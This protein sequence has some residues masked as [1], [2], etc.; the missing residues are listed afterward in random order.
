MVAGVNIVL[1]ADRRLNGG[2]Y[3]TALTN[4]TISQ[5]LGTGTVSYTSGSGS[6]TR[7]GTFFIGTDGQVHFA[8]D[9]AFPGTLYSVTVQSAPDVGVVFGTTA[10][11]TAMTGTDASDYIYGGN[12]TAGNGTG[13]DTISAGLGN[14]TVF[15]GDGND[16][17]YGG[18]G[19]DILYGMSG[20]DTL[21]G[22]AGDDRLNGGGGNDTLFGGDG[23]DS[24]DGGIGNDSIDGGIG[25][26]RVDGGAGNDTIAL[27]EGSNTGYGGTGGDTI[28]AGSGTDV[29]YGGAGRDSISAGDGSDTIFGGDSADTIDGGAGA[30]TIWGE[31]GN[32]SILGGDGNDVIHGDDTAPVAITTESMT[33]NAQGP[34]G[35]D[36][37]NGFVQDTGNINVSVS[38]RDDGSTTSVL[39]SNSAIFTNGNAAF[40]PTSSIQI[41]GT[42]GATTTTVIDFAAD[43]AS[44]VSDQVSNV[45]FFITDI[46]MVT[47]D[48]TNNFQDQVIILAYA[49]DGTLVPVTITAFGGDTVSSSGAGAGNNVITAIAGNDQ[50]DTAAGAAYISIPGPVASIVVQFVNA[51]GGTTNHGIYLSDVRFTT[52]APT[53]GDDTLDGGAGDDQIFGEAGNDVIYGRDGVDLIY[54]G[55]GNDVIDDEPG[56]PDG[57]SAD[58]FYGDAGDDIMWMGGGNDLGYGGTGNDAVYGQAGD[59]RLFGDAGNDTLSGDDG[60]D[61]LFGGAGRDTLYGGTG[62]DTL[63]GG[64]DA[65]VLNGGDGNDTLQG[66]AGNDT[67]SGDAGNDL[68]V[69][70]AGN[71]TIFGGAGDDTISLAN[72]WGADIVT[73]GETTETTGDTLSG[74][75]L[76]GNTT[77]TYTGAESGT[78]TNGGD[79]AS[80][81]EIERVITGSGADTINASAA[82][83][84]IMVE[85]G[86]GSDTIIGGSGND[87]IDAGSGNDTINAGA[88]ND[89]IMAGTGA[90]R[91][92]AGSGNDT[93]D[94]GGQDGAADV[95]VL[96]NGFGRDTLT[97]FDAI[98]VNGTNSFTSL[99]TL[100]VTGLLDA[101]GNPVNTRDVVVTDD[102]AG[103]ALLTFPGGEQLVLQGLSPSAASNE[104]LLNAI[105]IPLPDG[106]VSGTAGDDLIGAGYTDADG[107]RI[108]GNDS[109]LAG[110]T[111]N[112]DLIE[113]GAGNDTIL[114]G[115]G[116]DL[117]FAGTGNDTL[118]GGAGDDTLFGQA[119]RDTLY[120]GDGNDIVDGG[121]GGTEGDTLYGGAGNDQIIGDDGADLIAGDAGNDTIYANGGDDTITVADGFGVDTVSGGEANETLGDTLDASALTQGS[122][123]DLSAGI[124][125][126]PEDGTLTSG[127]NTVTFTE[128]ERIVLGAADDSVVG[129]TG[130]D[131]VVTGAGADIVNAGQGDDVIDLGAGAP[132]GDA[133]LVILQ[134]DFGRDVIFNLD[135]PV[136]NPDGSYTAIDTLDVSGLTD[137]TG[138]PVNTRDVVVSDDGAGNAVLTFPGGESLTLMGIDPVAASDEFFLNALGIPMSDGTVS[139]TAGDDLID[140]GYVDADGDAVDGD[141]AILPGSA[142]NDDLI[143]AGAGNDTVYAGD[144][145]DQVAGGAGTD[146]IYGGDGDDFI[147]GGSNMDFDPFVDADELYGGAGDD[148]IET[149]YQSTSGS[150]VYGGDG[151]DFLIDLGGT[152]SDDTFYGGAGMD[153]IAGG[154]GN[155]TIYGGT[156]DDYSEGGDGDDTFVINDGENYDIVIGGETGETIGDTLDASG[157]T[158][159]TV[160]DL[161]GP[162]Q[163]TLTDTA[164][165]LDGDPATDNIVEFSEIER[166]FLG[167]G[168]DTVF[169]GEGDDVVD[170]GAGDD[171]FRLFPGF[172]NDTVTGGEAGE[173]AGDTLDGA[174]LTDGVTVT[175]TGDGAGTL[176]D[177]AN[178]VTFAEMETIVTGSGADTI[179]GSATDDTILS[180]AGADTV[181]GG[182]GNDTIDLGFADGATDTLVL[183]DG[184]GNDIVTAFEG[185]IDN[186]DGTY[187]GRDQLDVSQL[188][189][190]DGMPVNVRDVVVTDDGAGNAVLTFPG[191]ETLTLP[192]IDPVAATDPM[193][194]NAMGIPL[195]D[196]TVYGTAGDDLIDA[197]YTGDADGDM[198]DGNDAILPGDSGNDDVIVAGD[199]NDTVLAGAGNDEVFGGSGND[200]LNGGAGDDTLFGETG[201]DTFVLDDG[202]G[203]DRITGGE[204]AGGAETDTIDGSGLTQGVSVTFSGAEAGTIFDGTDTL[205]FTEIEAIR[206]GAGADTI[207]GGA[208]DESIDAGAGDD[209]ID[210]GAGS[211]LIRG[212]AGN[213]TITFGRGDTISG[214]DG[215]GSPDGDDLFV[216]T[217]DPEAGPADI[218]IAGGANGAG[219][220]TLQLGFGADL[221]TLVITRDVNGSKSGTVQLDD[222]SLLSFSDI[223][224]IICFTPGTLIATPMGARD[225]ATLRIGDLVVTRDHGLQPIRWIQQR[226]VEAH[227][228]FAPIRIRPGV[229][230]GLERDLIVSPQHRMLFQGYRAELLF[231]ESEVLVAAKHLVDGL[232]V[233][234]DIGGTV[235]Y[236]HMM[237]DQHEVVYAEGAATESFH[238][239]ALGLDAIHDAARAELFAIFPGLRSDVNLYG[240]TARRCLKRHE[241]EL[242]RV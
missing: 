53:A 94:L 239:G 115:E 230:T 86:A 90:D 46:D 194:L 33:W 214:D 158:V 50:P 114:A 192:G 168:N 216:L 85:T 42:A 27:G 95:L 184:S 182:A 206:T 183:Q 150:T 142:G 76:T 67:L 17:V 79:T 119:G 189:D 222:G 175:L 215:L 132:D 235:T 147:S 107:D 102:G 200:T 19:N 13:G 201:D 193:F 18:A 47:G 224:N 78:L 213:D 126:N 41:L 177:G 98:V 133:D 75:A 165:T 125:G 35:T 30:D 219:G 34:T 232:S 4:A 14:D 198:V 72:G 144:G 117:V 173:V 7:T 210:G 227:D 220:D 62:A 211:D 113:A 152:G 77:V 83:G 141:D 60:N 105:G 36:V 54:G 151:S 236:I 131:R 187:T 228:R 66:D 176:T 57:T 149:A 231:G 10:N 110:R 69:G 38:F 52:I 45:G 140:T 111:G 156:G 138:E 159:D 242:L 51:N 164:S 29:I 148:L 202:F 109:V 11:D 172:G 196:G 81:S 225:I 55:D 100:D 82:T 71:D 112:D 153:D 123:L 223:E 56:G 80:F 91:V 170:L 68:L 190:A 161:T 22:D 93:I 135:A 65:D 63:S 234:R 87:S 122:V 233:T 139:G 166:F 73:G 28:T 204:D 221:S 154:I 88:G 205:T 162:E 137:L 12:T 212:G 104:F 37:R 97:G 169:G 106:T 237:F 197:G 203:N 195:P 180:G 24:I 199:G 238:P 70:G 108:D 191:G 127:G 103:N 59:D 84:G 130:N 118:F 143:V 241:A 48:G 229:V 96:Q 146:T 157:M 128:I 134:D 160:L 120:G 240:D 186:G 58:T 25:N 44:G 217:S 32:D 1:G 26:D 178:T 101:Q 181:T 6:G 9:T 155:D 20:N 129:S 121:D 21:Y 209:V 136:A 16:L 207:L 124:A 3:A 167:S 49:A 208:G 179:T 40:N 89:T 116:N 174:A 5:V 23:N 218:T 43:P 8:P 39:T 61:T 64:D 171:V 31:A 99:D 145:F 2:D 92:N 226:T 188:T 74:A 163:G 15:A 185:P